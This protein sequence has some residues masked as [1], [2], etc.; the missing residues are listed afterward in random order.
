Q[1]ARPRPSVGATPN[2]KRPTSANRIALPVIGSA[3]SR[4]A[5]QKLSPL[6]PSSRR[7]SPCARFD[8]SI[9]AQAKPTGTTSASFQ[10][11]NANTI[12]SAISA[13]DTT[14]AISHKSSARAPGATRFVGCDL[15]LNS[16]LIYST[17]FIVQPI[18]INVHRAHA[19]GCPCVAHHSAGTVLL[20]SFAGTLKCATLST[21]CKV[22]R[23]PPPLAC[24][25]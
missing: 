23:C 7:V 21:C 10:S 6:R 15:K 24:T 22:M 8:I 12:H 19:Q 20:I 25:A 4:Q 5:R 9:K 18:Q 11:V 13:D 16:S 2:Q 14:E 3:S 1:P 17:Q